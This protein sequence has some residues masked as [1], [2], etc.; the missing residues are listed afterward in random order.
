MTATNG[1]TNGTATAAAAAAPLNADTFFSLIRN[2]RTI[3]PLN[4]TLP[5]ALTPSRIREIVAEAVQHVP[6]AFNSQTN[7]AVVLL[8]SEHDKL[9]DMTTETLRAVVPADK[10]EP[11]GQKLAKFRGA[12]GTVLFFV[13]EAPVRE[14][15][16]KFAIYKDRFPVWAEHSTAMLQ[17]ALWTALEA[18]G[19]GANLQ[20]YNPLIDAKVA[21]EWKVPANWKLSAQLIFGGKTTDEVEPKTFNPVEDKLKV[22]GA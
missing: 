7:R 16:E 6:S 13:D 8:G 22:F 4:K 11:T 9:W 14:L 15:Q 19:L 5:A 17:F 1:T 3:Y 21:E 20:H 10:W 2:R 12:A 18:E